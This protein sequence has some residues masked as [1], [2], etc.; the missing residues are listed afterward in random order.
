MKNRTVSL[1]PDA[2]LLTY[3]VRCH[4]D[5][6]DIARIRH[7]VREYDLDWA[8]LQRVGYR[9]RIIPQMHAGVRAAELDNLSVELTDYLRRTSRRIALGALLLSREL[10][11]LLDAFDARGIPVVPYKGP[12][13]ATQLYGDA[14]KRQ[15]GDLDILVSAEHVPVAMTT[16]REAGFEQTWPDVNL[17]QMQLHAHIR[18]K[19]NVTFVR[20]SDGL[21]VELHWG[22]TPKYLDIPSDRSQLWN[23][24]QTITLAGRQVP[25]FPPEELLLILC[26][27]GA[28]HCWNRLSWVCDLDA[29]L[30][31]S[32]TLDWE[33]TLGLAR[34]WRSTRILH[35]GLRLTTEFL[36]TRLPPIIRCI[37]DT[38]RTA[39]ALAQQSAARMLST[40]HQPFRPFEEPLYHIRMRDR[41][42]ERIKYC[43]YMSAPST[44][45]W[46][47]IPL[48]QPISFLYFGLRP[49]RLL[50]KHGLKLLGN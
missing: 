10:L 38:D 32:P 21:H 18:E 46:S 39:G 9:N 14:A 24:L 20:P 2:E 25:A 44:R 15:G 47:T 31:T 45:D 19:Y 17:T 1:S 29:L 34:A 41:R 35:L 4:L 22:I 33:Y 42:S 43:L 3:L 48:P 28:N 8:Y 27:H 49:F 40:T 6:A 12:A 13:L 26:I 11:M 30:T 16:V 5:D 36:G 7:L 37:I 50:L 23:R